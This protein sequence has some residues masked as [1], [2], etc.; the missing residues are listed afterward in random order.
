MIQKLRLKHKFNQV[1]GY[2]SHEVEDSTYIVHHCYSH[3]MNELE[4]IIKNEVNSDY[5]VT[6]VLNNSPKEDAERTTIFKQNK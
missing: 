5:E 3:E 6:T 1:S 2:I 4:S